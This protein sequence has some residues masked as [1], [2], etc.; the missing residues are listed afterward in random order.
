[1]MG[2]PVPVST[3]CP[4]IKPVAG[5]AFCCVPADEGE[6]ICRLSRLGAS[7]RTN[8]A[9]NDDRSASRRAGLDMFTSGVPFDARAEE[10]AGNYRPRESFPAS[11]FREQD[12]EV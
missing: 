10:L 6:G 3:T 9:T 7:E 4:R 1:M 12:A 8:S 2:V 11:V 5:G